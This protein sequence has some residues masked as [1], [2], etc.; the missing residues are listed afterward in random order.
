MGPA[1]MAIEHRLSSCSTRS[2]SCP[3]ACG[4]FLDQGENPCL[5]HWQVDFYPLDHHG[6]PTLLSLSVVFS[7]T[8]MLSYYAAGLASYQIAEVFSGKP[9]VILL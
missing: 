9:D 7:N 2:L 6:S 1:V 4:I 5:L 3:E 8:H